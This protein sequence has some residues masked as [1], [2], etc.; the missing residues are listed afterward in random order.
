[1]VHPSDTLGAVLAAADSVHADGQSYIVAMAIAYEVPCTLVD[2]V[3][4]REKGWDYVSF[5]AIAA[6]LAVATVLN[7]SEQQTRHALSLSAVPN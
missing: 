3:G 4:L 5:S 2:A 1:M 6:A 7:L